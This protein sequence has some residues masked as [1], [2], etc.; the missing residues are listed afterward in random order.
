MEVNEKEKKVLIEDHDYDGIK[1]LDNNPPP[2]IMWLFYITVFWSA[3]YL[4]VFHVLKVGDLQEA[5]YDKE[6]A[7]ADLIK[8]ETAKT[9]T[10]DEQNVAVLETSE[11][12]EA[13]KSLYAS[14]TCNTCHGAEGEGNAVGPNL[15]DEYWLNGNGTANDVFKVIK[16]GNAAK[17]MTPFKDQL[18]D[19]QIQQLTSF[20][21]VTLKGSNP[22]NAKAAQGNKVN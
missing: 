12:L 3:F 15:T 21:L 7:K 5:E 10:F 11:A 1:E 22:P 17:G 20:V 4:V 6:I 8:K 16:H 9:S 18:T 14:K 19:V 13:G 2:W